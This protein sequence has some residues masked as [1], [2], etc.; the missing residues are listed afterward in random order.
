MT[1]S[2]KLHGPTRL[3]D[4]IYKAAEQLL[5]TEVD[6]HKQFRLIGV[7]RLVDGTQADRPDLADPD[8]DKRIKVSDAIEAVRKKFG[9]TAIGKG[10]GFR[11]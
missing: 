3:A 9:T 4:E 11:K 8:L 6:G 7:E 5:S 10:R 1:R 2:R